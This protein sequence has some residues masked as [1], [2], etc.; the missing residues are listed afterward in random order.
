[1][2]EYMQA[3]FLVLSAA[4]RGIYLDIVEAQQID[5]QELEETVIRLATT[6]ETLTQFANLAGENPEGK[7]AWVVT[8][9]V[10]EDIIALIWQIAWIL[11]QKGLDIDTLRGLRG[12]LRELHAKFEELY[13]KGTP[14]YAT[15]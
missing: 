6:A 1:M 11:H 14:K 12:Q 4:L 15:P 3:D 2:D 13:K 9:E 8:T 10:F 5:S 7:H